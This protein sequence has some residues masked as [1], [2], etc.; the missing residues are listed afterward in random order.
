MASAKLP[1]VDRSA[2]S[3]KSAEILEGSKGTEGTSDGDFAV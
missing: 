1:V 3:K 2:H